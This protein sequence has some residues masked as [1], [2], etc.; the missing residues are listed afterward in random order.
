MTKTI[1]ENLERWTEW[2]KDMLTTEDITPKMEHLKEY[3]QE[4]TKKI[5]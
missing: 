3:W 4:S 5:K 2:V 1:K